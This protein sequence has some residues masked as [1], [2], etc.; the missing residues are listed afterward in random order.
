MH[1]VAV[2]ALDGVS[3]F[4][5]TIPCQVF[6]LATH[7]DGTPAYEV[8]VCAE[9]AVTATAGPAEPFRLSSP[10]R[11]DDARHADTVV[12]PG[13]PAEREPP[14]RIVRLLKEAAAAGARV[15]SICTGAFVLA[16]AG[17]LDGRR[18]TTHWRFADALA[19][20]FPG[21]RVDP[22]VLFVD[23]DRVLTSA[24][25]AAGLDLCLHM[26]RR[27]HGAAVAA[28]VARMMV[29][30]PQRAGGQAQFIEYRAPES[31]S[32][33]LGGTMQWMRDKLAEPLT[34]ADIAAHAMMSRRSLSRHFLAQTGTTPL[35]WLLA[36]RLQ[37]ARELLEG[38]DLP[39]ARVAQSTG[40]G[41]VEAFRHH[42]TRHIGTTPSAYRAAF[43]M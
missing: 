35:R 17:L 34:V 41:S 39:V 8:R 27:D 40:F 26:V 25:I 36:H 33:D 20:R 43:R 2:L 28:Q 15:A 30:A 22:S 19:A 31:D 37:R 38:S 6:T 11:W 21:T 3:A 14:A 29:M 32:A 9:R 5:L 4:D 10:Y 7:P 13:V 42:F 1:T 12:V 23:D 16:H 24:G 18:A